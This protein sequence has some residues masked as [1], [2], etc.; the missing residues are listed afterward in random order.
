MYGKCSC[1]INLNA[2]FNYVLD[3]VLVYSFLHDK[4]ASIMFAVK[5]NLKILFKAQIKDYIVGKKLWFPLGF[6]REPFK[7]KRYAFVSRGITLLC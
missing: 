7:K 5:S 6:P 2:A 4:N 3:K 1:R